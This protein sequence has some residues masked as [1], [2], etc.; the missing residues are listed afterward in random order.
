M[1]EESTE[2]RGYGSM[3]I[4]IQ[5]KG[6]FAFLKK[7]HSV[8]WQAKNNRDNGKTELGQTPEKL[9]DV[10]NRSTDKNRN[11]HLGR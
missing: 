8:K 7:S 10:V 11:G 6:I 1:K 4:Q 9:H 5:S 3:F 2:E